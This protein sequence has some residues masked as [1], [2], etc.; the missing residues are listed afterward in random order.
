MRKPWQVISGFAVL[1][2]LIAAA[3]YG[4]SAV[5]DYTKPMSSVDLLVGI[6][7]FILC[8][9]SLLFA[10]C[11]DCEVIGWGGFYI[12]ATIGMLNAALYAAIGAVVIILRK[13]SG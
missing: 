11:V 3:T 1:G 2:L 13:K 6:A 8:P 10:T 4:W 9:P 7:S 5:H 12:F